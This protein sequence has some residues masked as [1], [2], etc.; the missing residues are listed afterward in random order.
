MTAS[1]ARLLEGGA[2]AEEIRT[3]VA[4]DVST[5][6]ASSRPSARVCAS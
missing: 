1:G 3:A 6:T 2:I 4:E 5:F